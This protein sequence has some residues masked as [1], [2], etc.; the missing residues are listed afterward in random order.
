M[1]GEFTVIKL[2]LDFAQ[3][4]PLAIWIIIVVF[5]SIVILGLGEYVEGG[6]RE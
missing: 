3:N 2:I 4:N 1:D 6:D 5:G